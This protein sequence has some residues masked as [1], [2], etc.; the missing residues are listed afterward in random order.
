MNG[1][2]SKN[3]EMNRHGRRIQQI[4]EQIDA[5]PNPAARALLHECIESLLGFYGSGLER[6]LAVIRSSGTSGQRVLDDLLQDGIVRGMLLIHGLHPLDIERRLQQAL[7]KVR[8]YMESH[9]G[10]VELLSLED[11]FARLRLSGECKSCPSSAATLELA[12]RNAIEEL[13]PDLAGFDVEGAVGIEPAPRTRDTIEWVT[14]ERPARL[15]ENALIGIKIS[16][17]ALVLC[18]LGGHLYAYCDRCPACNLPL[19]LGTLES[20]AIVCGTGH[21]FSIRNAGRPLDSQTAHL[22]PVPLICQNGTIKI[23]IAGADNFEAKD[24]QPAAQPELAT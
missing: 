13:C 10:D 19:H 18:Q 15:R 12:V 20:G 24:A 5:M 11:D 17:L 1:R 3:D 22:E 4:V 16:G 21:R 9:G 8:P 2:A 23:A 7:A 6:I 14:I